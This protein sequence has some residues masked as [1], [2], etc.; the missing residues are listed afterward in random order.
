MQGSHDLTSQGPRHQHLRGPF[1]G[2]LLGQSRSALAATS[3]SSLGYIHE[4]TG[5]AKAHWSPTD[6]TT[7][8][9]GLLAELPA[10]DPGESVPQPRSPT[11]LHGLRTYCS[12]SVSHTERNWSVTAR[13]HCHEGV[14][15]DVP[16]QSPTLLDSLTTGLPVPLAP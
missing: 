12:S 2:R 13:Q 9:P 5:S 6:V 10:V 1:F 11:A 16:P 14:L 8:S 15:V 3:F 4:D 7:V